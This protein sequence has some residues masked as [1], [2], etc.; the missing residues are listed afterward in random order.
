M[1]PGERWLARKRPWALRWGE[2]RPF[3]GSGVWEEAPKIVSP[4]SHCIFIVHVHL[5]FQL[6][7]E[8]FQDKNCT[9]FIFLPSLP[10]KAPGLKKYLLG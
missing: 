6:D 4:T 8:H 9:L 7:C 3:K 5:S 2:R 1:L 10:N